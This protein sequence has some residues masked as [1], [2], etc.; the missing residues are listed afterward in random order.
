VVHDVGAVNEFVSG[1]GG[2]VVRARNTA[3]VDM[4]FA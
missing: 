3:N 1:I 2:A 4:T